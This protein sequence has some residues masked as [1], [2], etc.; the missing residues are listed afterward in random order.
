MGEFLLHILVLTENEN[1]CETISCNTD[2]CEKKMLYHFKCPKNCDKFK[3]V[4]I[5]CDDVKSLRKIRLFS[6]ENLVFE[7]DVLKIS[8]KISDTQIIIISDVYDLTTITDYD[9]NRYEITVDAYVGEIKVYYDSFFLENNLRKQMLMEKNKKKMFISE[10]KFVSDFEK[11]NDEYSTRFFAE[12][13]FLPYCIHFDE[14]INFNDIVHIQI[15]M[16]DHYFIRLDKYS[17]SL[18][19]KT[20][21]NLLHIDWTKIK[22]KYFPLVNCEMVMMVKLSHNL[23]KPNNVICHCLNMENMQQE[24]KGKQLFFD[25]TTS[26]SLSYNKY[27]FPMYTCTFFIFCETEL[28][29]LVLHFFGNKVVYDKNILNMKKIRNDGNE[30]NDNVYKFD[31]FDKHK[32]T[33][34][35]GFPNDIEIKVLPLDAKITLVLQKQNFLLYERGMRGYISKTFY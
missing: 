15:L 3:L 29:E 25:L 34:L 33:F 8:K 26:Q 17:L 30:R 23:N 16:H 24:F 9:F 5:A 31:I 18:I 6:N 22:L 12:S 32:V 19:A 28:D 27:L 20:D 21:Y 2:F 10:N 14:K 7:E 13:D 4:S 35:R 11:R 1:A